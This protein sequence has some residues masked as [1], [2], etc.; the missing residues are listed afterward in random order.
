MVEK[1]YTT[2]N[3]DRILSVLQR[4][5]YVA[6]TSSLDGLLEQLL[7]LFVEAVFAEAGTLYL[8]D[9]STAELVF[10][11][12]KGDPSSQRFRNMRLPS[13][14]GI[15]GAALRNHAP[16]F[17]EDV[18]RDPR[19][20]RGFGEL[21]SLDLRTM[22]CLPLT[23]EE[24]PVGIVQVFNISPAIIEE[25]PQL[26]VLQVLA[27]RMASEIDKARLI[28]ELQRREQRTHALLDIISHLTTTLDRHELLTLIMNY[29]RDLLEVEATSIWELDPERNELVLFVSTGDHLAL[30]EQV[31]LQ[32]GVGLIGV[33][34][35]QGER[36]LAHNVQQDP[37][38]MHTLD[39][40]FGI[41]AH[42]ILSVPMRAADIH[43]SSKRGGLR[44][45][46]IGGAQA[47]NKCDGGTFDQDDIRLFEAL[48]NQAATVLQLSYL[49][50]ST[51]NLFEGIINVM[52]N[53]IDAKDPYTQG[54]SQRVADFSVAIAEELG[55][56]Q[57]EIYH[58]RIG[59]ILHDVGKIGVP[60]AILQKPGVLT[61][62]EMAAMREHPIRGYEIMQQEGLRGL[63]KAELPALLEHH[64]RL[65]GRGYPRGLQG[66]EIHLIGRIVAVADVF[67]AL[68]SERPYRKALS[69]EE[70]FA[71]LHKASGTEFDPEC[72][73]ALWRARQQNKIIAQHER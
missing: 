25:D 44:S 6:A 22:Y 72:V 48:V 28:E 3:I 51:Q 39:D 53:A 26:A 52:T 43:L 8:Y 32:L 20:L 21:S 24:R 5:N 63:L 65:D 66:D 42:T 45:V 38:H 68:T 23:L 57:E 58:V 46:V 37:R 36:I 41:T 27:N 49:Y 18:K 9:E 60:D 62:E 7:D 50:N 67:D 71:I 40:V 55:L 64:E 11:V 35:Q 2:T 17:V 31:R 61:D 54:H 30:K 69:F 12:V 14:L 19:W 4:A 1:L 56:P 15:A 34:V 29:A 73:A 70:A 33:C 47:I 10:K 16:L 59:G 13:H